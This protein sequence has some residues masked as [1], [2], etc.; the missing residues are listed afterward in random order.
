MGQ[1]ASR[2][3][4][5]S[6]CLTRLF[7]RQ[8][9]GVLTA[10]AS[11]E[12][13]AWLTAHLGPHALTILDR[14]ALLARL[15]ARHGD[16][17]L[18]EA[19]FGLARR[20][21][22]L[23]A[24]TVITRPQMIFLGLFAGLGMA[25]LAL[26]PV[27][28]FRAIAALL[29]L[30]FAAAGIFRAVLA[31]LATQRRPS[32]AFAG[33]R[34]LPTYTIL[35]PLYREAAV[36]PQLTRSL[37]A[38]DY[39]PHLL[40]IKLVMEADDGETI[41]AAR[42]LGVPFEIV[43]VP[44]GGPRTKPK[45]ANYALAFARGEYLVV[46]DAEDRPEPDQL[47]KAVATFRA[48]PRRTACLQARLNFFN[49]HQNWLTR[50]FAL[51]YA[52]WFEALLPGLD[53]IGVPIPLGG[54]SN[55]FRTAVLRAIGGWDAF[56]VT[57]D[58]DI[59]IRLSQLGYRVSML[60]STTFEEAPVTVGAWLK[61]RSRWLKGYMQ[62]WLVHMRDPAAL[63]RRTGLSGFLAFQLFI[64]GGVVFAL[65]NPPLWI[66]F[67]AALL[68]HRTQG[69]SGPGAIIPGA[70]LLACNVLLT[71]LAVLAPKR[72]GWDELAPYGLTVIAYWGLVSAAGYRGIWQLITRPFFWEKTVHG[73]AK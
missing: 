49:A 35:V 39:P 37:Q 63:M 29:S 5:L 51:D 54:T 68:L 7:L 38:L 17:L 65:A 19:V 12:N 47:R 64:G 18:D 71:W 31:I 69:A 16:A 11:S 10:D 40:D 59:G 2:D 24:Q 57:E 73:V 67:L 36:L 42:A 34:A 21:P 48:S 13:R 28:A 55:H 20:F 43:E 30:A 8:G 50:M 14:D 15:T 33:G 66:A 72:R 70:G 41:A 58:A 3:E 46:Y 4:D 6:L 45:A 44:A 25:A 23:S 61:Q 62:T 53:R 52:L 26:A 56:N 60:D 22:Q 1:G 9:D 27:P 32:P